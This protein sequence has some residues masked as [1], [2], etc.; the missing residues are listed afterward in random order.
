MGQRSV[1]TLFIATFIISILVGQACSVV[2]PKVVNPNYLATGSDFPHPNTLATCITCHL[3][4]RPIG[5]VGSH[6]WNHA[7]PTFGAT[8]DCLTCHS[9]VS[10]WGTSWLGGQYAHAPQPNSCVNCHSNERPTTLVGNPAFDHSLN[11]TGDCVSCHSKNTFLYDTLANWAGGEYIPTNLI[12]NKTLTLSRQLP[13]FTGSEISSVTSSQV[14]L[15]LQMDHT[16][17]QIPQGDVVTPSYIS[18]C[19]NCHASTAAGNNTNGVFH[20][21]LNRSGLPQ[22]TSCNECHSSA[23][24]TGFVGPIDNNR[25]PLSASMRH[26]ATTWQPNGASWAHSTTG[27]VTQDCSACHKDPRGSFANAKYHSNLST[28]P[29]SCIDCH[30]N[31]RPRG[32]S[33]SPLFDHAFNGGNADC[34]LCHN[35]TAY[36]SKSDWANGNFSHTGV[37]SCSGCHEAQRPINTTGWVN[38]TRSSWA[39]GTT[40]WDL[41]KHSIGNDCSICHSNV[42]AH[43]AITDFKGGNFDH[44]Q[45]PASCVNCHNYPS[46]AVGTPATDHA[47]F[48]GQDCNGCHTTNST[49][50][51]MSG[52]VGGQS[53][54]QGLVNGDTSMFAWTTWTVNPIS[55]VKSGNVVTSSTQ[56]NG[57]K[58]LNQMNHYSSQV[59]NLNNCNSCH[60]VGR[61]ATSGTRYHASLTAQ[62]TTDCLSCHNPGALPVGIVGPVVGDTSGIANMNHAGLANKECSTCHAQPKTTWADGVLHSKISAT[63][64]TNCVDCH[65]PRMPQTATATAETFTSTT[66]TIFT[67]HMSH[68][69]VSV[70]QDCATCHTTKGPVA[71]NTSPWK[72]GVNKLHAVIAG[73]SL[74]QCNNCHTL[75]KPGS[76]VFYPSATANGRYIHV[77]QYRG[78]T[79]CFTCHTKKNTSNYVDL[80][81]IGSTWNK[82]HYNHK[83]SANKKLASSTCVSCHTGT[84]T[85][86]FYKHENLGKTTWQ[87]NMPCMTCHGTAAF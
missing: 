31:S 79:D 62:P 30:S 8:G 50:A 43:T 65:F 81:T 35:V 11:G 12:G 80:T 61:A 56:T 7:D 9:D 33:G 49:Y 84:D 77:T 3:S 42:T 34:T 28:Q 87:I 21:S 78:D 23:S 63:S 44:T 2:R 75:D 37:T 39:A 48:G 54:P 14:T 26:E 71:G 67:Q 6:N 51:N 74:T 60:T 16:T 40:L 5:F 70:T 4:N 86:G 19:V 83:D 45:R 10:S 85:K 55:I 32:P 29:G 57:V 58:L 52:W 41:S 68:K 1:I 27:I 73:T 15:P 69:D 66:G 59:A 20:E 46:G 53:T 36:N 72:T 18:Q 76:T 22:P 64:I 25:N 82:G 38:S 24:P 17:L 13:T 47:Q